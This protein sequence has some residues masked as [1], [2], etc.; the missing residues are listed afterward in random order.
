MITLWCV[1]DIFSILVKCDALCFNFMCQAWWCEATCLHQTRASLMC[2]RHLVFSFSNDLCG[3]GGCGSIQQPFI[4]I[5][6]RTDAVMAVWRITTYYTFHI[7]ASNGGDGATS[8]VKCSTQVQTGLD[9]IRPRG[10]L[11]WAESSSW[12]EEMGVNLGGSW[13]KKFHIFVQRPLTVSGSG[14]VSLNKSRF[15]ALCWSICASAH[16]LQLFL[17]DENLTHVLDYLCLKQKWLIEPNHNCGKAFT[18]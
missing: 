17:F 4:L 10:S 6:I 13:I 14:S 18:A 8:S 9:G 12:N 16:N 15:C 5:L 11:D 7:S 1:M 2:F 3:C